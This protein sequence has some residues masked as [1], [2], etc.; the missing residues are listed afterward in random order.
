M[1]KI[2]TYY[3]LCQVLC[4]CGN[5]E[6]PTLP[7]HPYLPELVACRSKNSCCRRWP[8]VGAQGGVQCPLLVSV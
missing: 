4:T 7:V 1:F 2:Y 5:S 8:G 6:Y 3:C